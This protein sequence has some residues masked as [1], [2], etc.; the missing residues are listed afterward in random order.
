MGCTAS[1]RIV[2]KKYEGY[3]PILLTSVPRSSFPVLRPAIH[4]AN[5]RSRLGHVVELKS[6][7]QSSVSLDNIKVNSITNTK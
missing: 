1:R 6:Y 4:E 2:K 5:W 7:L 3:T